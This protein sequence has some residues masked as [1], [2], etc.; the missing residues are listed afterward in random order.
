VLQTATRF[1][2]FVL[3][4]TNDTFRHKLTLK[5]TRPSLITDWGETTG[6]FW[7]VAQTLGHEQPLGNCN[8][9]AE[10]IAR[11]RASGLLQGLQWHVLNLSSRPLGIQRGKCVSFPCVR[12]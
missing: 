5:A 8:G 11:V 10:S 2:I 3:H 6:S 4:Q 7:P 1:G 12:V 9:A